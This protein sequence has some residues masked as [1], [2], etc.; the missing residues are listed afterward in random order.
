MTRSVSIDNRKISLMI[1]ELFS[2][3]VV[4]K[5]ESEINSF[6][7]IKSFVAKKGFL[8][9][10]KDFSVEWIKRH[11]RKRVVFLLHKR[12]EQNE[13]CFVDTK[14]L[15]EAVRELLNKVYRM[16][17]SV[18]DYEDSH[19]LQVVEGTLIKKL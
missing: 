9:K 6:R 18:C 11:L 10:Q 15:Y 1:T 17:Y 7:T 12:R 3:D 2:N 14:L 19:T 13:D 4:A 5:L 8:E 16:F